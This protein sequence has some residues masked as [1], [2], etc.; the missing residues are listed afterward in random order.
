MTPDRT[1]QGF[2]VA[3][4]AAIVVGGQVWGNREKAGPVL[5]AASA[6][7]R[8]DSLADSAT[9]STASAASPLAANT[10]AALTKLSRLVRP[11]SHPQALATAFNSYFTFKA[12]HPDEVKKPYLYFVDYGLPSTQP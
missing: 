10:N 5:T 8:G 7:V 2:I 1:V 11:L 12:E 4:A 3:A 9:S 6:F